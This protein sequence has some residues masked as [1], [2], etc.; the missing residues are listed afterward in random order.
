MNRLIGAIW[1]DD[2]DAGDDVDFTS[3]ISCGN[4]R[5]FVDF[6]AVGVLGWNPRPDL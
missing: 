3:D 6:P 5:A 2:I 4:A 1:S